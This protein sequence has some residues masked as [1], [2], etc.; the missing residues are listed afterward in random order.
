MV[1]VARRLGIRTRRQFRLAL[2][3]IAVTTITLGGFAVAVLLEMNLFWLS[4]IPLVLLLGATVFEFVLSD[5]VAERSYPFETEKTLDLLER[6][7]GQRTVESITEKLELIIQSFQACDQSRISSTVHVLV[8]LD[9]TPEVGTRLGLLQLT[10]YVGPRSSGKG[11]ITTLD[12]GVI[13]RCARTGKPEYV[14]FADH[15]EYQQRMVAE[16]G[17]SD[18]E[19]RGH[20]KIARSYITE[21]LIL[22]RPPDNAEELVGVL[23]FFSTE[24]QVFPLAARQSDLSSKAVD[25]VQLLKATSIVSLNRP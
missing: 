1:R 13:G 12:Q 5:R 25:V 21:P 11:R 20:T 8:N 10:N 17:F 23:Y 4:G 24:L 9:P 3:G 7:L 14:N 16:F 2:R 15:A 22:P 6:Q 18:E 19:A